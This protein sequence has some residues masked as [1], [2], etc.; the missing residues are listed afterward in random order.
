LGT[1]QEI[2]I[3]VTL[4][5]LALPGL[6]GAL[7]GEETAD[8]V[9]PGEQE[10]EALSGAHRLLLGLPIS[11]NTATSEDLQAIPGLGPALA[12]RIIETRNRIGRFQS[13][14]ELATVK[15]IGSKRVERLRRFLTLRDEGNR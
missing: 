9:P 2:G 11:L 14:Q 4:L 7:Q 5:L 1:R 15:G 3:V 13:I 10:L 12:D 8:P 6:V